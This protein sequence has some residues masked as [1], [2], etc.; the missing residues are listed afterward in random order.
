MKSMKKSGLF[1]VLAG[2]V[3]LLSGCR[4]QFDIILQSN[5]TDVKFKAG[6]DYYNVGKF[7][8][9]AAIFESMLLVSQGTPQEDSVHYYNAM[10]NYR[11]GDYITAEANFAKFLEVFPRSPFAEESK[12]LR[13]KCLYEGTY[14][15]EL[16][17]VPT[18]KAMAIIGEFM[19]E[20][21]DSQYYPICQAMLDEFQERLD[22]KAY[23]AAKLYYNMEDFQASRYALKN[24]LKDNSDNQYREQ[25]LYYTALSSYKYANLSI[26]EKQKERYMTFIDDYYNFV[27]EYPTVKERKELDNYFAKAHKVVGMKVEL[28]SAQIAAVQEMTNIENAEVKPRAKL[29]ADRRGTKKAIKAAK[30]AVADAENENEVARRIAKESKTTDKKAA[31]LRAKQERAEALRLYKEAKARKEAE[32]KKNK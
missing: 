9:A 28:D 4:S 16:D 20:N 32:A 19:F 27:G 6:L 10:S 12:F 22:R 13:I 17:Q 31:K 11:Y 29:S 18:Q 1:A 21:P 26:P 5:D 3:L 30:K 2:L 8:K 23:E 15:W 7:R 25:I 14:R 24:V